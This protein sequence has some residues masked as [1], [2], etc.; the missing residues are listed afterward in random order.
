MVSDP[1]LYVENLVTSFRTEY[2][3]VTAIDDVNFSVKAGK[4]LAIVGE[5]GCGKSVTALS[6]MGL[7][8]QKISSIDH[9][10]IVYAGQ[11]ILQKSGQERQ[12]MRGN[13]ISM[14]F[15][16]PMTALNP[17]YTVGQQISEVFKIHR[18]YS[19]KKARQ[20]ALRM[21][22]E[23]GIPDPEKRLDEYPFQLSGGMR[24]RVMIAIALAC[25]PK[26]LI[27]DEPT[28]A[29]D[30]TVQA[31]IL[32]LMKKLQQEHGT[33][34]IFITH[35]LGVVAQVADEVVVMY[36]GKVIEQGDVYQIFEAPKHPYTKGLM[37]SLPSI[38]D[39]KD[40]PL[41]TIEGNVPSLGHLPTGCRFSTRCDIAN[42][43]CVETSPHL[44]PMNIGHHVSC[45]SA[46]AEEA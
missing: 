27:A 3:T 29:L 7:L 2:G 40:K 12:Q 26:I 6:I 9:G 38:N 1:L 42:H 5:S 21:L 22:I 13:E 8:P 20:E 34:I 25:E 15:Q 10:K 41:K 14:I 44:K 37:S 39:T 28:T 31:Q 18:N 19:N 11:D 24:Q 23:V 16:E 35:D 43:K 33:A 32:S 45:H 4:T 36:A 30:V 17:V 46:H